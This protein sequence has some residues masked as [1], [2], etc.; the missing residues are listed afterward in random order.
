[1][2]NRGISIPPARIFVYLF[3]IAVVHLFVSVSF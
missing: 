2:T 1:M 3:N